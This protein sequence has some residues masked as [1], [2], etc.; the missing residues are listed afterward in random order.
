MRLLILIPDIYSDVP[1]VVDIRLAIAENAT[2]LL[3]DSRFNNRKS[4]TSAKNNLLRVDSK[5]KNQKMTRKYMDSDKKL[6]KAQLDCILLPNTHKIYFIKKM[7]SL[8]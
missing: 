8:N 7:A 4:P 5:Q 2:M 1:I 3:I 6:K